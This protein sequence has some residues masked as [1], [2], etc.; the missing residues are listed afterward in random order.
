M[1]RFHAVCTKMFNSADNTQC[2]WCEQ[3]SK[4]T[5]LNSI[6]TEWKVT[7]IGLC[8]TSNTHLVRQ[9]KWTKLT[10]A[11]TRIVNID[12]LHIQIKWLTCLV[13][14]CA[15]SVFI[16]F[17]ILNKHMALAFKLWMVNKQL[18]LLWWVCSYKKYQ[19]HTR[20]YKQLYVKTYLLTASAIAIAL[21]FYF[22]HVV[23]YTC[24]YFY[25]TLCT[26]S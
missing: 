14:S 3:L 2:K 7:A 26:I 4:N 19:K 12:Q 16:C 5:Y 6:R 21:D 11:N 18:L 24:F 20:G 22:E 23:V 9:R 17:G 10:K 1:T 15:G 25:C 8:V 13:V